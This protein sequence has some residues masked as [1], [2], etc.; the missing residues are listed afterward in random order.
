MVTNNSDEING[1]TS[2]VSAV[3]SGPGVDGISLREALFAIKMNPGTYTVN[4]DTALKGATIKVGSWDHSSLPVWDDSSV[5]VNGDVDGDNQPDITLE[6]DVAES[7]IGHPIFAFNIRSSGNTING[8]KVTGFSNAVIFNQSPSQQMI[9]DNIVS[10]NVM[11]VADGGVGGMGGGNSDWTKPIDVTGKTWKNFRI[12][13]NII[14]SRNGISIGSS[15]SAGD[16]IENVVIAGNKLIISPLKDEDTMG[17]AISS[18]FWVNRQGNSLRNVWI[19]NNTIEGTATAAL[20][21]A[22][23]AVGSSGNVIENVW[24]RD[25]HIK[26]TSPVRKNGV[27]YDSVQITTGDGASSYA[28]PNYKP[29]VY[30]E[31]NV[32]QEIWLTGNVIEGQGGSGI[33]ITAGCCGTRHN[34]VQGLYLLGN[35]IRG[36]F[37]GSG[38]SNNG[39][40]IHASGSGP[41]DGQLSAENQVSNVFIQHNTIQQV[42][43]RQSFSGQEFFSGGI[44]LV[45]GAQSEHNSIRD[46]WIVSNEVESPV[47]GVNLIGGWSQAPGY[48][49]ADNTL[50]G[51]HI[52][53][54]TIRGNLT[55]FNPIFPDIK[56][57]N[58]AGGYG[59]AKNN[60]VMDLQI[61]QN[62]V[63]G[64]M[65]EISIYDNVGGGSKD[66][67]VDFKMP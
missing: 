36:F 66:N 25:N 15:T 26:I 42:N 21:I 61:D 34:K 2:S 44:T 6:N 18:G 23:G 59:L 58:L 33:T 55:L 63:A 30:P 65:D 9:S 35:E 10:N 45:G 20:Y 37:A 3:M 39:I 7:H 12:L 8:L 1:D 57:I 24:V 54:N 13:N 51:A 14:R 17:I 38:L 28:N 62:D 52:W 48:V 27:P 40:Y 22:A 16:Q 56:G 67:V 41:G 32:L 29:V 49:S 64:K 43:Q 50:S 46:I 5:I 53:C 19:V 60:Q 31:N 47:P 11:E 4:F